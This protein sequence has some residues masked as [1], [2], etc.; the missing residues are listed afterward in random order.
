MGWARAAG[1]VLSTRLRGRFVEL[2]EV[3]AGILKM[4]LL[5]C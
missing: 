3:G 5:V 2:V 4:A 1:A